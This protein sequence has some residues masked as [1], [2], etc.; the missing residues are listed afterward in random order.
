MR[1]K[2]SGLI[3]QNI[4]PVGAA[5]IGVYDAAGKRRAEIPLGNLARPAGTKLFSFGLIS[6]LHVTAEQTQTSTHF[7]NALTFFEDQGC[8]FCAHG[9]DMTTIGFWY[10]RGDTEIYLGQFAEYKRICG[11]H[12][13][14][15]V[16]GVCGNHE[17]YNRV[18][19]ENLP[20]L[21]AY[22]GNG[23]YFAIGHGDDLFIFIGEPSSYE[24][25]ND[26]EFAWFESLLE[27]N[28]GKRCHVFTHYYVANDSGNTKK[29]YTC[30][31]GDRVEEFKAL[32]AAHGRAIHYHGH[33]HIKF[34]CQEIDEATNYTEKNGFPSVHIPSVAE[35][36]NVV[37]Q[38]DGTWARV[39]E[40][41]CS[42]GYIVDV[43]D[44]CVVLNG[45]DLITG[46]SIPHGTFEI[47]IVPE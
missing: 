2:Y 40:G 35:S 19:T 1:Y 39:S 22:T 38:E 37:Q 34:Q 21:E 10:N 15:P 8:A 42:Q 30:A 16:Y 36:R 33:S 5:K 3:P 25:M 46:Q 24:A 31:F 6:D 18:I 13:N 45:M 7:D 41:L 47:N 23:L 27:S 28:P 44:D 32:M 4:A 11:L 17:N 43:Y 14:L 26:E 12:P 29:C 20:E 9:G